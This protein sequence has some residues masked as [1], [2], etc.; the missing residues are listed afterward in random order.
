MRMSARVTTRPTRSG[1]RGWRET[2]GEV[3]ERNAEDELRRDQHARPCHQHG[4]R[5]HGREIARDVETAIADAEDADALADEGFGFL[6]VMRMQIVAL[7]AAQPFDMKR[8]AQMAAGDDDG[9]EDAAIAFVGLDHPS[10]WRP[11]P[12]PSAGRTAV[13]REPKRM[14]GRSPKCSTK[15]SK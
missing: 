15:R 4:A 13:T 12:L 7:E 9:V 1:M 3:G 2:H 8:L 14:S 5:R 11:P 10:A 6:V